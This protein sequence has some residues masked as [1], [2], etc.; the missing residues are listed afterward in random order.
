MNFTIWKTSVDL[1]R[2]TWWRPD[3]VFSPDACDLSSNNP[4]IA[5]LQYSRG[6]PMKRTITAAACLAALIGLTALAPSQANAQ[7]NI[8]ISYE[9]PK[10]AAYSAILD[11]LRKRKV[12][13]TLQQFLSPL[14]FPLSI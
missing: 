11:R 7:Q 12:L 6:L 2:A 9:Q 14:Q 8:S 10:K 5:T 1:A 4:N 13:E 3:F